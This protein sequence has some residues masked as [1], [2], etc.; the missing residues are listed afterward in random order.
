VNILILWGAVI[1]KLINVA[2]CDGLPDELAT[3]PE[4]LPERE[5]VPEAERLI[6]TTGA[7]FR[8]GGERAFYAAARDF[9]Q[10][11]PQP[12]FHEQ[13][14]YYRTCFHE[15]GHPRRCLGPGRTPIC[16]CG[17]AA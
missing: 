6:K 3:K 4:P 17:M 13:I 12:A 10:V 2:Q 8:I 16:Q 11:P 7:D 1:E 5:I 14:Y 15:L 9:I